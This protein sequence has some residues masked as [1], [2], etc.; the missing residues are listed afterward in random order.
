MLPIRGGISN[1][2]GQMFFLHQF[3]LS[4]GDIVVTR[5]RNEEECRYY[6]EKVCGDIVVESFDYCS[7]GA[8]YQYSTSHPF[9]WL[10]H[11]PV[12]NGPRKWLPRDETFRKRFF[13][14][15]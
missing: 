12:W 13:K 11:P 8:A 1:F 14:G 15:L 6:L 9:N 4:N 2:G 7:S 3:R 10:T 5:G